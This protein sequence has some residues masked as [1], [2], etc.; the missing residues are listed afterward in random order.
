MYRILIYFL[1]SFDIYIVD[2]FFM[3]TCNF[4]GAHPRSFRR[5][6][7]GSSG[8]DG[9]GGGGGGGGGKNASDKIEEGILCEAKPIARY[10][11]SPCYGKDCTLCQSLRR[12]SGELLPG[13]GGVHFSSNQV[14]RFVNNYEAILNCP[15]VSVLLLLLLLPF[16]NKQHI[17]FEKNKISSHTCVYI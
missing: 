6:R 1:L 15:A 11:M 14:H 5:H 13:V 10:G 2:M 3:K 9:G 12:Q 16:D 7:E 17:L 8:S 4:R